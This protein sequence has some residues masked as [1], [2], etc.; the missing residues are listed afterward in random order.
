MIIRLLKAKNWK[1]FRSPAAIRDE[2]VGGPWNARFA[3]RVAVREIEAWLLA[4]SRGLSELPGV[5][6]NRIAVDVE[7]IPNPKEYMVDLA[8]RSR[9][10]DV[11]DGLVP[12]LGSTLP[13]G[14]LYDVYL[15]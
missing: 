3:F 5:P 8:R 2:W 10:R 15:G 9:H 12:P 14:P 1:N 7:G 11:R 13:I 6:V 4:D